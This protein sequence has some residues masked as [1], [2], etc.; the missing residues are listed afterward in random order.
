M[1][2]KQSRGDRQDMYIEA[3]WGRVGREGGQRL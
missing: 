2:S 3:A 1:D